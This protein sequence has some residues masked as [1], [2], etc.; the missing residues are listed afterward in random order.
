MLKKLE[1]GVDRA[2]EKAAGTSSN[3]VTTMFSF[4]SINQIT[5]TKLREKY[6]KAGWSVE[7]KEKPYEP[8]GIDKETWIYLS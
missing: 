2:I 7:I 1:E 6:E 3:V 8:N 5:K 4:T